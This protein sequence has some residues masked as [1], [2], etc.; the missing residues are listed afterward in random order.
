M[1]LKAKKY[2]ENK[3]G[4]LAA[5]AAGL[6]TVIFGALAI[7]KYF[8]FGYNGLDLGIINQ[9]FFNTAAGRWFGASIHPPTYLGDHFSPFIFFLLPAYWL[10]KSPLTLIF[11]QLLALAGSSWPLY[12]LVKEQLGRPLAWGAV[13]LW[14]ANPFVANAALFEFSFLPFAVFF[15]F[16]SLYFYQR[17]KFFAFLL[18][19]FLALL[20]RED[21][22]LV[23]FGIG[24][25]SLFQK[26]NWRWWLGPLIL[27]AG[28]FFMALKITGSYST[29]G[30]YKFL[31][32]YSW[33]GDSYSSI[34]LNALRRPWLVAIK[35]VN[36]GSIAVA[37]ALMAPVV[38]LPLLSPLALLP[39]LIVYA[40]LVSGTTINGLTVILYTHY[41]LLLMPGI[42]FAAAAGYKNIGRL[43]TNP[44]LGLAAKDPSLAII[45]ALVTAIYAS[46]TFGP[47]G[48]IIADR[49]PRLDLSRY[50][51]QLVNDIPPGAAV[52]AS[53]AFLPALSN[54]TELYSLNYVYLGKQQFAAADY[55]LPEP[56]EYLAVDFSDLVAYQLQYGLSAQ[57]EKYYSQAAPLWPETISAF[58]VVSIHDTIALLQKNAPDRY[59]LV[60]L[61]TGTPALSGQA[62]AL[63]PA[64]QYLGYD[65]AGGQIQLHWQLTEPL[66]DPYSLKLSYL[67][68]GREIFS[69]VYPFGYGLLFG[70]NDL[71]DKKIQTNYWFG[72]PDLPAGTYQRQLEVIMI[73][74][75]QI[76]I[77]PWRGTDSVIEKSDAIGPALPLGEITLP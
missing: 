46:I 55:R 64:L 10:V 23:I 7:Y 27:S 15:L 53:Y 50:Q 76:E 17:D 22:A 66:A 68:S 21:V 48:G 59:R 77:N 28:Y 62:Q 2:W 14:L 47:L 36:Y 19:C 54:R 38:F 13:L 67:E 32:Y 49:A 45:L 31:Q 16:W 34:I 44:L 61:A 3:A 42:Y 18:F 11:L 73:T 43:K 1:K 58:G 12:L 65:D 24:C 70:R 75:G 9:V 26:R 33:L 56:A 74:K 71:A 8:H 30:N 37:L 51:A 60:E 29:T 6:F 52:A 63:S 69:K 40:Q 20:V 39:A 35:L 41:C 4:W 57:Y 25:L 5:A 72:V